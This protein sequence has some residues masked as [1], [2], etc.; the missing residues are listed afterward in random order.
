MIGLLKRMSPKRK[1][2]IL[3]GDPPSIKNDMKRTAIL[4]KQAEKPEVKGSRDS[5][6]LKDQ[7]RLRAYQIYE[8]RGFVDGDE[9]DDWLQAEAELRDL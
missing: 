3:A 4:S 6:E 7:I 9:L 2:R 1:K 8:E 5:E